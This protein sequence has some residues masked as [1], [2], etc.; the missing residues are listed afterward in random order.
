MAFPFRAT[1]NVAVPEPVP[2][3]VSG[4]SQLALEAASQTQPLPVVTVRLR[5]PAKNGS[6]VVAGDTVYV[7]AASGTESDEMPSWAGAGTNVAARA[8]GNA[9]NTARIFTFASYTICALS[10][11]TPSPLTATILESR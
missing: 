5:V 11:L 2:C 8:M 6:T 4:V 9:V 7:H 3:T 1:K 10:I